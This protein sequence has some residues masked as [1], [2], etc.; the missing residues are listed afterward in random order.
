MMLTFHLFLL[1]TFAS[2]QLT[3]L[4]YLFVLLYN[5]SQ[6]WY[7]GDSYIHAIVSEYESRDTSKYFQVLSNSTEQ[8][9]HTVLSTF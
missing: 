1:A 8:I 6:Y 3:T 7:F 5:Y 9:A 2:T 4:G